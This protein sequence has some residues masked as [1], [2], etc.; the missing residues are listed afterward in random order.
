MEHELVK[1]PALFDAVDEK[2][3]EA[4][5]TFLRVR[6]AEYTFLVLGAAAAELSGEFL[7]GAGPVAALL[8]FGAALLLRVSNV[9][10]R[11]EKQW[12]DARAAAESIKSSS[13]QFAVA[14]EAYR[15]EGDGAEALFK[16]HL[17]QMLEGLPR[18][19]VPAGDGAAA[20]TA[21]MRAVRNRSLADRAE[22]YR[23]DRVD[24]QMR[25][26]SR[27]AAYNKKMAR[28]WRSALI[29]VEA[30]AVLLGLGRVLE[31]YDVDWLGV[32]AALA[33]SVAA[34]QQTKNYAT[35]AEAYSVTSHDVAIVC[36]SLDGVASEEDWA[37]AV[38]DAEA[39]F[40]REH[41]LWL[42]RKQ[43]PRRS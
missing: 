16:S 15:H 26:Y 9:A 20:V 12:Y 3:A 2:S 13:W 18:L 42:A 25:W 14:G 5:R 30:G 34:W 37:Q 19:D 1:L 6:I 43:G 21:D 38:H 17:K 4:Q 29:A 28:R 36:D 27:K 8:L 22:A 24:D 11:A 10:E 31:I 33:A 35:L 23:G 32:L 41:T 40:S 39:A 7:G